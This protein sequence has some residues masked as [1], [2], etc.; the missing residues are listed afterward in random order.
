MLNLVS[1]AII[2]PLVGDDVLFANTFGSNNRLSHTLLLISTRRLFLRVLTVSLSTG[3]DKNQLPYRPGCHWTFSQMATT[4][5]RKI[6]AK[7]SDV[8]SAFTSDGIHPHSTAANL[9]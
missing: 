5:L 8:A 4:F 6:A 1:Q 3:F 2:L 7:S 9:D